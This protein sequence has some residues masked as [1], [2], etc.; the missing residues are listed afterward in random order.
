MHELMKLPYEYDAL[1]PYL[2]ALTM[3]IHH[4]KH[5]ATYVQKLND[6]L[7]KHPDLFS[8]SIEELLKNINAIPEDIRQAVRNFGGG[9]ANHN[10]Y[11][12]SMKPDAGGEPGGS[13]ADA[14]AAKFIDF[15]KFRELFSNSAAALFGS[16]WTWLVLRDGELKIENTP[17]QD[18]PLSTGA[19]PLLTID[20]WEHAYYILYNN[21]RADYIN[22]WWNVVDWGEVSRRF[23]DAMK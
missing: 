16:G 20:V 8:K 15:T 17:N 10:F 13:L 19:V 22:N 2:D 9:V 1:E 23:E 6:A 3:Q 14:I 4:G 11:W 12:L 18:S 5:H 21:R 7:G